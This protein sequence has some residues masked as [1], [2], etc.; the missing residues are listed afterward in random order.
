M[1]DV[2]DAPPSAPGTTTMRAWLSPKPVPPNS[3]W[4]E[5]KITRHSPGSSG[6]P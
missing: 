3:F 1:S 5:L 6:M 4:L 2:A